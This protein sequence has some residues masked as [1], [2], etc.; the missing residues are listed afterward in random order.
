MMNGRVWVESEP[1]KGSTFHF[2]VRFG[3]IA[4]QAPLQAPPSRD[5]LKGLHALIIDD[6]AVNRDILVDTLAGWGVKATTASSGSAGIEL[7]ESAPHAFTFV[8]LDAMMPNL[9]GFE[10]AR[11]IGSVAAE[12]RPVLIMLSSAG[13]NDAEHW[14]S[15]GITACVTKPV[16]QSELLDAILN[17]LGSVQQV[18]QDAG[19]RIFTTPDMSP[20]DILVVEDHP[21]NQTLALTML[22]KWGHRPTLAQDGLEAL[23]KLSA[24]HYDLVLMDMQMPVMDGLEATRRFRAQETGVRTPIVAMTAN[25]ME[26]DRETCLAAGMDDYLSKP[27]R[28][29][30]LLA[31]LERYAPV[32]TVINEFDYA[33]ALAGEDREIL[34]IVAEPFVEGFPKDVATMRNAL[35]TRDLAVLQ[36]TAHSIKGNCGIFGATPMVKT[37]RMIEQYD[38]G[39]DADLD[40]DGLITTL[41]DDFAIL[42]ASLKEFLG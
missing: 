42:A 31:F 13:L 40:V 3:I 27:I 18:Q 30:D 22:E 37:A 23:D 2:V 15:V 1:G 21:V 14:R 33:G 32:R 5:Y 24:H 28:A 9:D 7:I 35:A 41:A 16:L 8:L 10:T 39:R 6:N 4:G 17:A 36:R 25:A 11:I 19:A 29:A 20:M 38:P 26:G 34:E 12:R